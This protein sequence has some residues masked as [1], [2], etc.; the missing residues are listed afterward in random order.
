[1]SE[2]KLNF[3]RKGAKAQR[4]KARRRL[5]KVASGQW[6]V[7]SKNKSISVAFLILY[8]SVVFLKISG[9]LSFLIMLP[10][11]LMTPDAA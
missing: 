7:V 2:S 8:F 5:R 3:S 4:R 9:K 6:P 11:V 1:V 10:S